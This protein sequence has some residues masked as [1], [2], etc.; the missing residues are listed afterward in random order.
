LIKMVVFLQMDKSFD[1]ALKTGVNHD[2]S[3]LALVTQTDRAIF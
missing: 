1:N 3:R 2:Y